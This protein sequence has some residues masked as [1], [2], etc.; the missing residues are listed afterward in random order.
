M[1][2]LLIGGVAALA[3]ITFTPAIPAHADTVCGYSPG[4]IVAVGPTSCPFALNVA[5]KMMS[6]ASS[7]FMA[8]SPETHESYSMSCSIVRHGSVTCVGGDGA[9]AG[10]PHDCIATGHCD[11]PY[12]G[13]NGQGAQ[14]G[15]Y[16]AGSPGHPEYYIGPDPCTGVP[17]HS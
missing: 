10:D 15:C 4:R 14:A 12:T 17:Y 16:Y 6:G 3:A 13:N 2:K 11:P 1:R 5:N 7:P 9:E 8:Y